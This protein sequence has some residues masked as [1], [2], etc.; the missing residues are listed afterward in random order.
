MNVRRVFDWLVDGAPGASDS[1]Q[2]VQ[3]MCDELLAAGVPLDRFGAFVRTLHPQFMGRAFFWNRGKQ[4]ETRQAPYQRLREPVFTKS[5]VAAI[6]DVKAPIRRRI[7][8]VPAPRDYLPLDELAGEGFTDYLA[9]PLAFL[10]GQIHC[11]TFATKAPDGFTEAHIE[12]FLDVTR[13]LSRIAEILAL[14]RTAANILDTYVGRNAGERIVSGMIQRGD[15]ETI[16]AVIW[17]SDLRGFTQLAASS[18]PDALLATLNELFDCQV[19][20]IQRQRGEVL[21]FMGDGLLAIFPSA[22]GSSDAEACESAFRAVE[23]AR[24][25]AAKLNEKRAVN[26]DPPL[27]FGL[28]LHLGEVSYGNIGGAGRLDFTCIGPAVNV[29]SRLEGL[30]GRVDRPVVVSADIARLTSRP[31]ATLGRFELKGVPEPQPVHAPTEA[32]LA[33]W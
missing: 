18:T 19:P 33:T 29:A 8:D 28:A 13:P 10:D 31:T 3:R 2:V 30:T 5:I 17:F 21:K 27:R 11:V 25:E 24:A 9:A 12:T 7:K 23:E 14:R 6:Y 22:G 4:V 16:R 20:A 32:S 1:A 15:L 26:G